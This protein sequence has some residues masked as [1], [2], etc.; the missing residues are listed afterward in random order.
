L[1]KSVTIYLPYFV[2][3]TFSTSVELVTPVSIQLQSWLRAL[4]PYLPGEV[5]SGRYIGSS[6]PFL[7]GP[8]GIRQRR[9]SISEPIGSGYHDGE[10]VPDLA[11]LDLEHFGN[12]HAVGT[13]R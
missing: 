3:A 6:R 12:R 10:N 11:V 4:L 13:A 8:E 7:M 5:I 9:P 1:F 2:S